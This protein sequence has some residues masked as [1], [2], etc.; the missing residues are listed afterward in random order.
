MYFLDQ[1]RLKKWP[2]HQ[3][4]DPKALKDLSR[5]DNEANSEK[6]SRMTTYGRLNRKVG[7]KEKESSAGKLADGRNK[8]ILISNDSQ[9]EWSKFPSQ[10][11]LIGRMSQGTKFNDMLYTETL[12]NQ[13]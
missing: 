3:L 10:K 5:R 13:K 4:K 9:C 6:S 11:I 7:D 12:L 2:A 1:E 8:S